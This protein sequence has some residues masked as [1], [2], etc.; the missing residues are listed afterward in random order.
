MNDYFAVSIPAKNASQGTS[1]SDIVVGM[2]NEIKVLCGYGMQGGR[3]EIRVFN[4]PE[5]L[6][7]LCPQ[8]KIKVSFADS[9]P[10]MPL[11]LRVVNTKWS[12]P[13]NNNPGA[14]SFFIQ[15]EFESSW[16][17]RRRNIINVHSEKVMNY[18][19]VLDKMFDVAFQMNQGIMPLNVPNE[20]SDRPVVEPG[21]VSGIFGYTSYFLDGE[22]SLKQAI[23]DIVDEN[24]AEWYCDPFTNSICVGSPV[25]TRNI[26]GG[27]SD[28]SSGV[29]RYQFFTMSGIWFA[30]FVFDG[31]IDVLI[32]SSL[33]IDGKRWKVIK[34]AYGAR[35]DGYKECTGIAIQNRSIAGKRTNQ[36]FTLD[37]I[38]SRRSYDAERQT[39]LVDFM[40]PEGDH[41]AKNNKVTWMR[42]R[43]KAS[44]SEKPEKDPRNYIF[45]EGA[46]INNVI[47]SSP[48]AGNGV[49]LKFPV[50]DKARHLLIFPEKKSG[51]SILTGM[52]WKKDDVIPKCEPKDLYLRMEKGS[53]YFD[54]ANKTWLVKAEKVKL[55]AAAPD[56]A[57]TKPDPTT[58]T[59]T[60]IKLENGGTVTIEGTSILLGKDANDPVVRK[61][62]L[63]SVVSVFNAH[64]HSFVEDNVLVTPKSTTATLSTATAN[65]STTTKSE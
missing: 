17:V 42:D 49:G 48:F 43:I 64:V 40:L 25:A 39:K 54:E 31:S 6:K 52:L 3:V 51:Y 18:R 5:S 53:L 29:T 45:S 34:C 30:S 26:G 12:P 16:N 9:D 57:N 61:S 41:Y 46:V 59:G 60:F 24:K 47:A 19:E 50:L 20:G 2:K 58:T 11:Q 63:Q 44:G 14:W 65:G 22:T 7:Q 21:K 55:E 62:D 33:I 15:A 8:D 32:G 1:R 27:S 13:G 38:D 37:E 36:F 56:A 23:D 4:F 28:T 35:G 10:N